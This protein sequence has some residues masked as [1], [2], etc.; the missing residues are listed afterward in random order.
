MG[1]TSIIYFIFTTANFYLWLLA[2]HKQ[3][4]LPTLHRNAL[5]GESGAIGA[6]PSANSIAKERES[7]GVGGSV[8]W[9]VARPQ[10]VFDSLGQK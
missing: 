10:V 9:R 6:C 7:R 8:T 4:F 3:C 2:I 1:D 5:V